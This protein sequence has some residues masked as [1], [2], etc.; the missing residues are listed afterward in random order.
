MLFCEN[1]HHK[2]TP[3][4]IARAVWILYTIEHIAC[5]I[6]EGSGALRK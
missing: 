5:V 2:L 1:Q 4:A 6:L 3:I